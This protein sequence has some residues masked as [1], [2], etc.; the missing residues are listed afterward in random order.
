ML[1]PIITNPVHMELTFFKEKLCNKIK[2]G[3]WDGCYFNV[4]F[5]FVFLI[6]RRSNFKVLTVSNVL[7]KD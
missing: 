5:K 6:D 4:F 3:L 1:G 7:F 2:C